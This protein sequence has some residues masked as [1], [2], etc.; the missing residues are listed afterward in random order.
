MQAL[1]AHHGAG[2]AGFASLKA[3]AQHTC[4]CAT[5][6]Q[7]HEAA[8]L[9]WHALHLSVFL[10]PHTPDEAVKRLL[11]Q[12]AV[13]GFALPPRAACVQAWRALTVA[14][15]LLLLLL[16]RRLLLLLRRPVKCLLPQVQFHERQWQQQRLAMRRAPLGFGLLQ[17][18]EVFAAFSS[19]DL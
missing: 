15:L 2:V 1:L 18:E 14:A 13:W 9:H 5:H 4:S 19:F 7:Q 6:W 10:G 3:D 11:Q 16:R 17:T 8:H 12:P